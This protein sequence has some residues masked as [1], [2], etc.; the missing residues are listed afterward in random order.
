MARV[1]QT[2]SRGLL[3][4]GIVMDDDTG[5]DEESNWLGEYGSKEFKFAQMED[6]V[7]GY[8][9]ENVRMGGHMDATHV[10]IGGLTRLGHL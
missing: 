3:D 1:R 8:N 10:G 9:R 5:A 2:K 6:L 4:S 7:S